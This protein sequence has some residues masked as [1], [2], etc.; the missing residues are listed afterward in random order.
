MKESDLCENFIGP[1]ETYGWTCYPETSGWDILMVRDDVQIGVQAKLRANIKVIAQCLPPMY[2]W[3]RKLL[4]NIRRKVVKRGPHYR[5]ILVP[6]KTAKSTLK[7]MTC[8]G[9]ALGLWVF[10]DNHFGWHLLETGSLMNPDY[11]WEPEEPEW[12]PDIILKDVVPGAS[13]PLQC[14]KWKQRA[15]KL[16]ARALVRGE[17]TSADAKELDISM[18]FFVNRYNSDQWLVRKGRQ[19]RFYTYELW[20]AAN[21]PP[22]SKRPDIEHPEA[23]EYFVEE[24]KKE[25]NN[26][27]S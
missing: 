21:L 9:E 13:S 14:T 20:P 10:T 18:D 4:P 16:L 6:E 27:V 22:S 17:V 19:G 23:F 2:W 1:A 5:T 8:I 3:G 25:L 11:N 15:L 12:V 24:E 7:D 26:E